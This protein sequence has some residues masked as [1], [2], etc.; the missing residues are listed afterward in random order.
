MNLFAVIDVEKADQAM[1]QACVEEI[2]D[3]SEEDASSSKRPAK[4]G[5]KRRS[6]K[7][8]GGNAAKRPKNF[9]VKKMQK[10]KASQR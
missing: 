8:T 6:R 3:W 2:D 9:Y 7:Q 10:A 1:L 4:R 5:V